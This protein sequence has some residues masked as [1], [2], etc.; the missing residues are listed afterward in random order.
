MDDDTLKILMLVRIRIALKLISKSV[1][2][3]TNLVTFVA[4]IE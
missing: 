1:E 4:S 3:S 2:D